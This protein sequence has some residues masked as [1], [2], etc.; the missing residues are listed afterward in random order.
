[1]VNCKSAFINNI[2]DLRCGAF[3]CI[4]MD[5]LKIG[6][7]NK[8]VRK[9]NICKGGFYKSDYNQQKDLLLIVSRDSVVI[10][11]I[12]TLKIIY[13]LSRHSVYY[14]II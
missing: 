11:S 1:M 14:K 8:I 5:D 13:E 9:L 3:F 6:M 4:D 2:S 12:T 7:R 10:L